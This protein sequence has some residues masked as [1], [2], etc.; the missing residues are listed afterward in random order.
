MDKQQILNIIRSR[1]KSFGLTQKDMADKLGIEGSQYG[2]YELGKNEMS[3]EKF[4]QISAVL[5]LKLS[6]YEDSDEPNDIKQEVIQDLLNC[7]EKLK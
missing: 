2:R 6:D 7:I 4:L 5:E 1:R 3:L